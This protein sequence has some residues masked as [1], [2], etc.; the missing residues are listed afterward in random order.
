MLQL[1]KKNCIV[2][3]YATVCPAG[4]LITFLGSNCVDNCPLVHYILSDTLSC[5]V[6]Y[7]TGNYMSSVDP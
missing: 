1:G 2:R 6:E 7:P 4:Q 3:I 5:I